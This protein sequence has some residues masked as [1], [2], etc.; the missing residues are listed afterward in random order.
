[1]ISSKFNWQR[2]HKKISSLA[3]DIAIRLD[4]NP[5]IPEILV[6]RGYNNKEINAFLYSQ[7]SDLRDPFLMHDMQKA[8]DRIKLAIS[9]GQKI[10]VYGDYDADGITSTAIM[11]EV[12]YNMGANVEYFVPNRFTDGYGPNPDVYKKLIENGTNLIVTVDN[13]ISGVESVE[14]AKKLGCDVIITDHH[15]LPDKLPEAYAIVHAR[16]PDSKYPFGY[17]S[18]VGIA[19]K[20]ATAL[21][22]EIPLE[23]LDL[24][25][26]GTIA[27]LVSLTDENRILVK[28]GLQAISN[29][30]RPGL[31]SLIHLSGIKGDLDE[32]NISFGIAPRLNALGRMGDASEGVELL[33][34]FD[35]DKAEILAKKTE[36]QNKLR[37]QLVDNI[38]TEAMKQAEEQVNNSVLFV[39]GNKWHEGV[40][41]IVASRLVEKFNKPSLVLNYNADSK[42]LKGSGRS[43]DGFD[44]FASLNGIRDQMISFGGHAMAVG[45]TIEEDSIST[46]LTHLGKYSVNHKLS[47]MAK[48]NLII[49]TKLNGN[50][51]NEKFFNQLQ[52]LAPFGTDNE[53][54]IFEFTPMRINNIKTMGKDNEHLKFKMFDSNTVN[55]L[56][57]K[58]GSLAQPLLKHSEDITIAGHLTKNIW[59]GKT[60][61]QVMLNDMFSQPEKIIDQRTN[62]L[63][64]SMF[65]Q[66]GTYIFFDSKLRDKLKT[67]I[68]KDSNI[69]CYFD[70]SL[71]DKFDNIIVVDC[72]NNIL[73]FTDMLNKIKFHQVTFYLFKSHYFLE[74]GMPNRSEYAKIFKFVE[75]HNN[76]NIHN[77]VYKISDY[78]HVDLQKLIFVINVFQELDFVS[79]VDGIMKYNS[80]LKHRNLSDSS[81]YQKREKQIEVEQ[82]LLAISSNKF[83]QTV[84]IYL[85]R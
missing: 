25:A 43:I 29:T 73:Y 13:G 26:I 2:N 68:N 61:I 70:L 14:V 17:F 63:T 4:I 54:P 34:T 21:L 65:S 74:K 78:L 1:M 46:V 32:Q 24:V 50:D 27:D 7:I 35:E 16:Y 23:V 67:F 39:Y 77:E 60:T 71:G 6:R 85:N 59:H 56:A 51:V 82:L 62:K 64:K 83:K 42:T 15:E 3:N 44:L 45:L 37:R 84:R 19:F 58:N 76:V 38:S 20:L 18:G 49:T 40:L 72:P 80:N 36:Q 79:I 48:P 75:T 9:N 57:F 33:T 12:L 41:G 55:V 31:S 11:Y 30:E 28:Y 69:C 81:A 10:T 66:T 52:L 8:C 5:I 53:Y 22:G 47:S